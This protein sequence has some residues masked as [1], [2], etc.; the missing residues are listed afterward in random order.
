MPSVQQTLVP[1]QFFR[2]TITDAIC[3]GVTVYQVA[4]V[5]ECWATANG[6]D[7]VVP[8]GGVEVT[9]GQTTLSGVLGLAGARVLHPPYPAGQPVQP[10]IRILSQGSPTIVIEW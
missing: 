5:A 8:S 7:P 4:N 9:D 10:N 2:Y 6:Q 3:R 1:N